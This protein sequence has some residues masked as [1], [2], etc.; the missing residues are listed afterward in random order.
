VT[1]YLV[2]FILESLSL[3]NDLIC[4]LN[5]SKQTADVLRISGTLIMKVSYYGWAYTMCLE[6]EVTFK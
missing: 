3:C 2:T 4:I 5:F 6:Y 1:Y